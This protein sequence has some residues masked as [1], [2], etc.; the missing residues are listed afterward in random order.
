M[1]NLTSQK[2]IILDVDLEYPTFLQDEH[3]CF[4]LA[5]ENIKIKIKCYQIIVLM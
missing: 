1:I 3:N 5:A 2:G 4:S